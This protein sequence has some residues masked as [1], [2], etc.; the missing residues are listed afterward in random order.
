MIVPKIRAEGHLYTF[1]S[2]GEKTGE[3]CLFAFQGAVLLKRPCKSWNMQNAWDKSGSESHKMDIH[4]RIK[5]QWSRCQCTNC[6]FIS[7]RR[8]QLS[9]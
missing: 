1:T 4:G 2:D 7:F 9:A 5:Q 8:A 3:E 6:L